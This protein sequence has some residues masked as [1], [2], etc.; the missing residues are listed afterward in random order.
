MDLAVLRSHR[1]PL[2]LQP[3][4]ALLAPTDDRLRFI[5]GSARHKEYVRCPGYV[6]HVMIINHYA[7]ICE[8]VVKPTS[9]L[10]LSFQPSIKAFKLARGYFRVGLGMDAY[11]P[12]LAR[13]EE[14]LSSP[15]VDMRHPDA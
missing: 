1:H 8:L 6:M 10:A 12:S 15:P 9:W 14:A 2:F 13:E 4:P 5:L 7:G 3:D 11:L